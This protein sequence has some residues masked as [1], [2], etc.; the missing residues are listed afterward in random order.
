MCLFLCTLYLL[1]QRP[2][3]RRPHT[4]QLQT[5]R[6]H[7]MMVKHDATMDA[8]MVLLPVR[9]HYKRGML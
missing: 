9:V 8:T 5:G 2:R 3:R 4:L 6:T 1:K 7:T